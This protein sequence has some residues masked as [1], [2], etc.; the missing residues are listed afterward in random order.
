[1]NQLGQTDIGEHKTMS[2]TSAAQ[3]L[4]KNC[5]F[6]C[7]DTLFPHAVIKK[8]EILP[9]GFVEEVE[10]GERYFKLP[11]PH[12]DGLCTIYDQR[13][14]ICRTFECSVL[15]QC[16]K[17][18]TSFEEAAQ[19]IAQLKRQKARINRLLSPYPGATLVDR[20]SEFKRQHIAELKSPQFRLAHKEL[21]MEW[22]LFKTR[23]KKMTDE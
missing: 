18:E 17:G 12:F 4:C 6:C 10:K 20:Y 16:N 19:L 7:D 9:P 14:R 13:P 2:D 11:C 5:G 8:N 22:V 3:S 15:E 1:M 23:L 21:L